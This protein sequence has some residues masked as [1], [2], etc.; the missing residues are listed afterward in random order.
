MAH[1]ISKYSSFDLPLENG[2]GEPSHIA[3][4]GT[5]YFDNLTSKQYQ[6][7]NGLAEWVEFT[8]SSTSSNTPFTGGTVS[9]ATIFTN[10]LTSNTISAT[11]YYNLP[12]DIYTTGLTFNPSN[13]DLT[14]NVN[15]G[16]N[17]TQN[18]SILSSDVNITGGTYNNSTGIAT[19]TNNTGGTFNVS[20]FITGFT[21]IYVTGGTYS[22]QTLS[23]KRNDNNNV[24]I[25]GFTD[26]TITGI[27]Y[28]NNTISL[29][30]NTG[31]TLNTTINLFT[32]LTATTI[33]ATTYQNLPPDI[34]NIIITTA[35]SITTNTTDTSG[36]GQNGRNVMI[37]NGANAIN[38]TCETGSTANF[39]A[40][41]TKL[42]SSTITFVAGSGST[43]VQVDGTAALSG[44]VGST[45]CLTRTNNTYYLQISNR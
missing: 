45:A 36:Y 43:L 41:Y 12:Q 4:M 7:K 40:S 10:G 3:K 20:G 39:V 16:S 13:Y 21:D 28:N 22:N 9:G 24:T 6:N 30:N 14:I 2:Y 37:S 11:T 1:S 27:S 35:I 33:S 29:T 44:I 19:F 26:V 42:G 34:N 5:F 25:T 32:G 8:N 23:L 15:D 17:Y 18:L 31:G 38:L